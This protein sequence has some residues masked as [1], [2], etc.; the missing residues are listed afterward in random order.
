MTLQ[1]KEILFFCS[2]VFVSCLGR[3]F[4]AR[5][6]SENRVNRQLTPTPAGQSLTWDW[7]S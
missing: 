5:V 3:K 2:A 1:T 4:V 6:A 7:K